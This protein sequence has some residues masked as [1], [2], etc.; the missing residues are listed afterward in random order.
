MTAH[1]RGLEP[2]LLDVR[3]IRKS[4]KDR[5]FDANQAFKTRTIWRLQDRLLYVQ[6]IEKLPGASVEEDKR[7]PHGANARGKRVIDSKT[8]ET[9][10]LRIETTHKS[11]YGRLA[12]NWQDAIKKTITLQC[13]RLNLIV[14]RLG[15]RPHKH[16]VVFKGSTV[17]TYTLQPY[18]KTGIRKT[19]NIYEGFD[20][21]FKVLPLDRRIELSKQ[22]IADVHKLH[23]LG[24]IHGDIKPQNIRCEVD[25]AGKITRLV[26]IDLQDAC[27]IGHKFSAGGT[28]LTS[29]GFDPFYFHSKTATPQPDI[30]ALAVTVSLLCPEAFDRNLDEFS[31]EHEVFIGKYV[32]E[33]RLERAQA[34]SSQALNLL[35]VKN[36]PVRNMLSGLLDCYCAPK[37]SLE[38]IVS[39]FELVSGTAAAGPAPAPVGTAEAAST[40]T[41]GFVGGGAGQAA[42]GDGM[43]NSAGAVGGSPAA[44][45]TAEATPALLSDHDKLLKAVSTAISSYTVHHKSTKSPRV[46]CFF[47]AHTN[48]GVKHAKALENQ[49]YGAVNFKEAA[50]ALSQFARGSLPGKP[51]G[52]GVGSRNH[53]LISFILE[54]LKADTALVM[55]LNKRVVKD[56][57]LSLNNT[58]NS[59]GN[60]QED[61]RKRA[62]NIFKYIKP[63]K[64]LSRYLRGEINAV[65]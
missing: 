40:P 47:R 54:A 65:M 3:K 17:K 7:Y 28:P 59:H 16:W 22:L 20:D 4:G 31:M 36:E 32:N 9:F 15:Y 56:C 24:Y 49:L 43:H 63:A 58:T 26:L 51:R 35:V 55:A 10:F 27:K 45:G 60:D 57:A 21:T 14:K 11:D 12:Q 5:E 48:D 46:C 34:A 52:I 23:G 37:P 39:E 29:P 8:G 13:E 19:S 64:P 6:Y 44:A 25:S 18:Y 38:P 41:R 62:L 61:A 1:E 2:V 30:Y 42:N 33:K 53:S 50:Q